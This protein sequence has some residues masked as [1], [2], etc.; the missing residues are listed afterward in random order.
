MAAG[1][2]AAAEGAS[3]EAEGSAAAEEAG[4]VVA[5]PPHAVRL[6][7]A[8][9]ATP[10]TLKVVRLNDCIVI[11]LVCADCCPERNDPLPVSGPFA[12]VGTDPWLV[13]HWSFA[14]KAGTDG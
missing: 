2:L 4:A 8:A 13:S 3:L 11:L 10:A 9:A 14:R 1:E 7:R 5:E 12:T 6:S